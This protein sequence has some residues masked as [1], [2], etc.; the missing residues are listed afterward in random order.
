MDRLGD[1]RN[2]RR[3][4]WLATDVGPLIANS[5]YFRF[6]LTSPEDDGARALQAS[7]HD[8]FESEK[9]QKNSYVDCAADREEIAGSKAK[10]VARSRE[11]GKMD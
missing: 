2:A 8:A 9:A 3:R 6:L 7:V 4:L 11:P 5:A 1:Q 10:T